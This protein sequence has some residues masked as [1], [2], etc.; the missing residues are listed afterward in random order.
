MEWGGH[1]LR[2]ERWSAEQRHAHPRT[3][4]SPHSRKTAHPTALLVLPSPAC[5]RS[6]SGGWRGGSMRPKCVA[7]RQNAVPVAGDLN[8]VPV[9]PSFRLP[10]VRPDL[11]T[12]GLWPDLLPHGRFLDI[13]LNIH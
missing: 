2:V 12:G 10:P 5:H 9:L 11:P 13:R 7:A 4:K 8:S 6:S 1:V 3:A